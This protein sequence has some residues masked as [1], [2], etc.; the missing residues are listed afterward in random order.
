[1][2]IK[3]IQDFYDSKELNDLL[4]QLT[5]TFIE[6]NNI[7]ELFKD[8]MGAQLASNMISKLTG[9]FMYLNTVLAIAE[10][11]LRAE[12]ARIFNLKK[13]TLENQDKKFVAGAV[14]KETA[15]E[16]KD[17]RR[18]RNIVEAYVLSCKTGISTCQSIMKTAT[19]E[20]KI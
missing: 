8:G 5:P 9:Y 6:V 11:E 20:S 7:T 13:I 19:E 12:E 14:E 2:N 18:I 15:L 1:M 17:Y 10:S 4:L 16:V 3:E